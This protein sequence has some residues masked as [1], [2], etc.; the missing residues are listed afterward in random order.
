MNMLFIA[1]AIC[2]FSFFFHVFWVGRG[3]VDELFYAWSSSFKNNC[4]IS[5]PFILLG[6]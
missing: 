5:S 3:V 4:I 6:R 1:F 2:L